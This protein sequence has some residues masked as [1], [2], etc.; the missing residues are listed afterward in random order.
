MAI[1]SKYKKLNLTT[2]ETKRI[3]GLVQ[4][5]YEYQGEYLDADHGSGSWATSYSVQFIS[6]VREMYEILKK[7]GHES[8]IYQITKY[9]QATG[10]KSC[11]GS[12]MNKERVE[13]LYKK[14]LREK[15]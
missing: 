3:I 11:R 15:N 2:E 8:A 9:L 5:C 6:A 4:V 14:Y 7:E 12:I 1:A 10:V 13:Y